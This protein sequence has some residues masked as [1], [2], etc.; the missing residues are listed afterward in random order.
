M[1][2]EWYAEAEANLRR[3]A[4]ILLKIYDRRKAEGLPWPNADEKPEV[5]K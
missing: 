5:K 3:Y 4:A 1:N 2:N